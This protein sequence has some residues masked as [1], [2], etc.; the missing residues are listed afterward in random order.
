[1]KCNTYL[2]EYGVATYVSSFG[3]R[4][5]CIVWYFAVAGKSST[6][7]LAL[8]EPIL[9]G[10]FHEKVGA[11]AGE[12]KAFIFADYFLVVRMS[13]IALASDAD[14]TSRLTQMMG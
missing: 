5:R 13:S 11:S 8:G 9:M 6:F 1:M 4:I 10:C 3:L 7:S 2:S 12:R 14:F